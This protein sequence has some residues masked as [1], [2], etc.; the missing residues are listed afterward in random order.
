MGLVLR[1]AHPGVVGAQQAHPR[2]PPP[3]ISSLCPRR[4]HFAHLSDIHLWCRRQM[5]QEGGVLQERPQPLRRVPP[6]IS[7]RKPRKRQ[8]SQHGLGPAGR[9]HLHLLTPR[10]PGGPRVGGNL[11]ADRPVHRRDAADGLRFARGWAEPLGSLGGVALGFDDFFHHVHWET[12]S[13]QHHSQRP[14]PT[15]PPTARASHRSLPRVL[16]PRP[17][18]ALLWRSGRHWGLLQVIAPASAEPPQYLHI[19]LNRPMNPLLRLRLLN[20]QRELRA[21]GLR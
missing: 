18:L 14:L 19:M 16:E 8:V 20:P 21:G 11:R 4:P 6:Y 15:A 10:L 1:D 7:R 17:L 2:R 3:F 5:I 13:E 9:S 12:F